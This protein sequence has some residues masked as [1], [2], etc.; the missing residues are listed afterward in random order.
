[1]NYG[2]LPPTWSPVLC[3]SCNF[4]EAG[5]GIPP[6]IEP[7]LE[8]HIKNL[9]GSS[10]RVT[11]TIWLIATRLKP[12][13][14][15]DRLMR[16]FGKGD[17]LTVF[18]VAVGQE[19]SMTHIPVDAREEEQIDGVA[20]WMQDHIRQHHIVGDSITSAPTAVSSAETPAPNGSGLSLISPSELRISCGPVD[21]GWADFAVS[22]DSHEA[23]CSASY[24]GYHPLQQLIPLPLDIAN[25]FI[26]P[27]P[28][29]NAIFRMDVVD[30]PGGLAIIFKPHATEFVDVDV[31]LREISDGVGDDREES[32]L[33]SGT[34][35]LLDLAAEVY[36][37]A[38]VNIKRHGLVGLRRGWEPRSWDADSPRWFFPIEAF[39]ML[40]RLLGDNDWDAY[41]VATYDEDWAILNGH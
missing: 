20:V 37:E 15:V 27:L 17:V 12:S 33:F 29:D 3:I 30:E 34:V 31:R 8:Q 23:H 39:L 25:H 36:R 4:R 32:S 16:Y 13:Q 7:A 2:Q 18:P 1:M 5:G 41:S 19:W 22:L 35:R 21:F 26:D 11:R 28:A 9:D 10:C 6:Q 40:R 14:V 38:I 24:L